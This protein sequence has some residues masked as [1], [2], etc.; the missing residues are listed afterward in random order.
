MYI[1]RPEGPKYLKA[2][3]W[4]VPVVNAQFLSELF[5]GHTNALQMMHSPKYQCFNSDQSL[6]LDYTLAPNLMGIF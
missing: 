6:R 5:L 1:Y 2:R 3:E 4:K